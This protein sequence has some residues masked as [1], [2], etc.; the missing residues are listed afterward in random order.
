[1]AALAT[2]LEAVRDRIEAQTALKRSR[3]VDTLKTL[4]DHLQSSSFAAW[5]TRSAQVSTTRP[6]DGLIMIADDVEIEI[7]QRLRS[8]DEIGSMDTLLATSRAVR[9]ALTAPSW[10]QGAGA[11][12]IDYVS[13]RRT[14][15]NGWAIVVLLIRIRRQTAAG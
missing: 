10:Y 11:Q 12:C 6:G 2:V 4:P 9:V 7:A 1:M 15:S 14:R 5:P 8:A 13:E 3:S